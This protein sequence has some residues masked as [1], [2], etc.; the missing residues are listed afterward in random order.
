MKPRP[1]PPHPN[2]VRTPRSPFGWLEAQLLHEHWLARLG[3]DA[4]SVLLLLA[5]AADPRGA[6]F[7]SRVRMAHALGI[8]RPRVDQA[9]DRL[10]DLRLVAFKP[11][12]PGLKDGVW[13]LLPLVPKN[14][15]ANHA[16]SS[17]ADILRDLGVL[18]AE[19]PAAD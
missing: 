14:P 15:S 5:L 19:P 17:I 7:F 1:L 10:L 3:P 2:L 8:A 13:Q 6:S 4:T 11:W 18:P 9:L 16:T 12:R